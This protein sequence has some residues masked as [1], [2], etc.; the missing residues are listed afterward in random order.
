[1]KAVVLL[2]LVGA[3]SSCAVETSGLA[4]CGGI[5]YDVRPRY[6]CLDEEATARW[7]VAPNRSTCEDTDFGVGCII[8]EELPVTT[9][10]SSLEPGLVDASADDEEG[11]QI[12]APRNSVQ[13]DLTVFRRSSGGTEI[14]TRSRTVTPIDPLEEAIPHRETFVWGCTKGRGGGPGWTSADYERGLMASE[15][16]RV[17][18]VANPNPFDIIVG[19]RRDRP[20]MPPE[21]ISERIGAYGSVSSV[22]DGPFFGVWMAS[23]AN[24]EAFGP[25]GC[26]EDAPTSGSVIPDPPEP[27]AIAFP[28]PDVSIDILLAC[29]VE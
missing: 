16:V 18:N 27:D 11:M 12:F 5:E 6:L 9:F 19:L 20:S 25:T 8:G 3:L 24:L 23:P 1:M 14:C 4:T 2:V 21:V 26:D 22:F 29:E 28:R 7:E 13:I 10:L 17:V 15:N